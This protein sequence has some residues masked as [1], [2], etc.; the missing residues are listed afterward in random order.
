MYTQYYDS[1]STDLPQKCEKNRDRLESIRTLQDRWLTEAVR[2]WESMSL[3]CCGHCWRG[4]CRTAH[5]TL[6]QHRAFSLRM[7]APVSSWLG[8]IYVA[9]INLVGLHTV[10]R[11]HG[12]LLTNER[13]YSPA[14]RYDAHGHNRPIYSDWW[15]GDCRAVPY[16]A[17]DYREEKLT[18]RDHLRVETLKR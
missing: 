3:D 9:S 6:L 8:C 1:S 10:Q 18:F 4:H 16:R 2:T 15:N 5:G 11:M 13:W 17:I 7:T 14:Q 12:T